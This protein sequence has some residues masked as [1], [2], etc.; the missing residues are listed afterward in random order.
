MAKAS[1]RN[2]CPYAFIPIIIIL[3]GIAIALFTYSGPLIAYDDAAYLTYAHQMLIGTFG[4]GE[5]TYAYGFIYPATVAASMFFGISQYSAAIPQLVEYIAIMALTFLIARRLYGTRI[6]NIS[7]LF[8]ATAPFVVAYATRALPD[9]LEGALAALAI[10]V[11]VAASQSSENKQLLYLAAGAI[12]ALTIYAQLLSSIFVFF[13]ACAIIILSVRIDKKPKNNI[14]FNRIS[15]LYF[16]LGVAIMLAAYLMIFYLQTG[17]A[18]TPYKYSEFQ[19]ANR[20]GLLYNALEFILV[21]YG[22]TISGSSPLVGVVLP[23]GPM[24]LWAIAG[25]FIGY[26]K[27]NRAAMMFAIIGLGFMLYLF[28]GTIS[29]SSYITA[30]VVTRY[31]IVVA[32]PLAILAAYSI[33]VLSDL[34]SLAFS[35]KVGY[36]VLSAFILITI[37]FNAFVMTSVYAYNYSI[38][39]TTQVLSAALQG[40]PAG[41]STPA[42]IYVADWLPQSSLT[43]LIGAYGIPPYES[44]L[45]FLTGFSPNVAIKSVTMTVCPGA[46]SNQY[47]LGMYGNNTQN[48]TESINTWLSGSNCVLALVGNYS[49]TSS[50]VRVSLYRVD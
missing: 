24:A 45:Y 44:F 19:S 42:V 39:A 40:I 34:F 50:F 6:A 35:N 27:R 22:Y 38:Y 13:F 12:A 1:P 43:W 3:I 32:A 10:Y 5:S 16:L 48:V 25:I 46:A 26:K 7:L 15:A 17:S 4:I 21:I 31:F 37:G 14:S 49:A 11:F 47:L 41:G 20:P 36:A 2:D 33:V 9:M 23:I 28:F 30:Y 8:V 18:L 29:L